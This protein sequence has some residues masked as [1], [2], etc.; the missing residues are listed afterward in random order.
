[1]KCLRRNVILSKEEKEKEQHKAELWGKVNGWL[2][3]YDAMN[4]GK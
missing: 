1:M 3:Q 4:V 2:K